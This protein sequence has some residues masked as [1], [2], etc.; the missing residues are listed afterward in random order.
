MVDFEFIEVPSW[1]QARDLIHSKQGNLHAQV[2]WKVQTYIAKNFIEN[3]KCD[4]ARGGGAAHV[5]GSHIFYNLEWFL[6]PI[7][8]LEEVSLFKSPRDPRVTHT[9]FSF[10]SV[11]SNGNSAQVCV[12]TNHEGEFI[13]S[14][15]I[16]DLVLENRGTDYMKHFQL[17]EKGLV[18]C[19][20]SETPEDGRIAIVAR[21]AGKFIEAVKGHRPV[22]PS[23]AA[24]HRV[25]CLIDE[26]FHLG[27]SP[28]KL[29]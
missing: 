10:K 1:I 28:L 8:S 11:H 14:W 25:Q 13:H 5:F 20:S 18:I 23:F 29:S 12:D 16:D 3:W 6:G 17:R 4:V 9:G 15:R 2:D 21:M 7:K 26:L 24:G 27:N 19:D 22:E